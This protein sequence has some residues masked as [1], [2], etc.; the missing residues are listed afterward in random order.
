MAVNLTAKTAKELPVIDG[1]QIYVGQAGI[2]KE[3]K[4]DLTLM[5]LSPSANVAGVFTQ[6]RFCAAP[7]TVCKKHLAENQGIRAIVVNTGNAN[8]GTGQQGIDDALNIC[9]AVAAH[10]QCKPEQVLPLSTG[11]I[12]EPLPATKIIHALPKV[13]PV[14][15]DIAASAIMTTDTVPK[16]ATRQIKIDNKVISVTGIAKGAGMIRPNM[17]TMLS[18]VATDANIAP[19]LLNKWTKEIA[20]NSF[21]LITV[22]G[23]T[24]TN[25]SFLIIATGKSG[26]P[27]ISNDN[28]PAAASVKAAITET[29]LEL[30]KAIVRDGE[31]ATKFITIQIDQARSVEEARKV[32]YSIAHS[33]LVKTAF[34]AS[35]ANLGRLLCAIGNSGITDLDTA[36]VRMFLD[37]V[38]VV[39]NGGRAE[40]YQEEDGARVMAKPEITVRVELNRGEQSVVLYTC[41]LSHDYVSINADYRS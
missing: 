11:V 37:S 14:H 27:E 34:F 40:L 41:D 15:W 18:F 4:N 16:A 13:K 39:E 10:I 5:L 23:D 2:K 28:D 7:V 31:G 20:D 19:D 36:K 12:L 38:L 17:A 24:S 26:L 22:D 9:T 1:I 3:G 6:N 30:A 29:A 21:N 35:D 25:D 8:A 33:P 32:G